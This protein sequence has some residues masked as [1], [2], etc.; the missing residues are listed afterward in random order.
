MNVVFRVDASNLIGTGHIMRCRTLANELQLR[1]AHIR[2]ITRKHP[3]HL[4]DLLGQDGFQVEQLPEPKNEACDASYTRLLKVSQEEDARQTIVA[5]N[6]LSCDLMIVDHYALDFVWESMVRAVALK[7]MVIDDL[8]NRPHDCDLLLDQNYSRRGPERYKSWVPNSCRLLLGQNFALL[9]REYA[10]VLGS[11]APRNGDVRKILLYMG[12]SDIFNMTGLALEALNSHSLQHLNVDVVIGPNFVHRNE[13][14]RLAKSRR[15][16]RIF[17]QQPHLANLMA[18]ADLSI[19]AGGGT[20]WERL[21]MGLSSI[22]IC[23]AENQVA[24]IEAMAS[25]GLIKYLG[26]A[27]HTTAEAIRFAV[28]QAILH[29]RAEDKEWMH[30]TNVVDGKGAQRV[31]EILSP[32]PIS[33]LVIRSVN[34]SDVMTYFIWANDPKVRSSAIH[35]STIDFM[36][37]TA[38]FKQRLD[39]SDCKLYVLE[40]N[41][42]PVGQIRFELQDEVTII[43]YSLDKAVRGR[44]WGRHLIKLGIQTFLKETT[45][46][47]CF[48]ATVKNSNPV[49]AAIFEQMNFI[50]SNVQ[51]GQDQICFQLDVPAMGSFFDLDSV[52][53]DSDVDIDSENKI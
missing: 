25:S 17:G 4:A 22:V 7:I 14:V 1:G 8:A 36:T 12:G 9:R 40:A 24:G 27:E 49:S 32:T 29:D 31:T 11:T 52:G 18:G 38:W 51:S 26:V 16:T 48:F 39:R 28:E 20:M 21:C 37:H 44:G 42:L 47:V 30:D 10:Q 50:R 5:L 45:K 34:A 33:K 41:G 23:T 15:N 46:P 2:F 19:G 53:R 13:V 3:G 43:D 35:T 6:G